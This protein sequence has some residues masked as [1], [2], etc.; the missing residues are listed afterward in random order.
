[1]GSYLIKYSDSFVIPFT[2]LDSGRT[3]NDSELK[4]SKHSNIHWI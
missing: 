3:T 1:M 4:G 2:F